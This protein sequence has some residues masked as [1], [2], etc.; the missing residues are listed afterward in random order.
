MQFRPS[1]SR[2][3]D[4]TGELLQC[5]YPDDGEKFDLDLG[6]TAPHGARLEHLRIAARMECFADCR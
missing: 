5:A 3:K 4:K 6:F 2:P 1:G